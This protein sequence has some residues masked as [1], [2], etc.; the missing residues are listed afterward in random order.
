MPC[1]DNQVHGVHENMRA[2]VR[3]PG[4]VTHRQTCNRRNEL[5]LLKVNKCIVSTKHITCSACVLKYPPKI[6]HLRYC[7][8]SESVVSTQ[9]PMC[10]MCSFYINIS[11]RT[12]FKMS[13]QTAI[14]SRPLYVHHLLG[15]PAFAI[16][17]VD[18]HQVALFADYQLLPRHEIILAA[19][20]EY[21]RGCFQVRK[22]ASCCLLCPW[23]ASPVMSRGAFY[24]APSL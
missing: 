10:P 24:H 2:H 7:V 16:L 17:C 19:R 12:S 13:L 21:V 20:I 9:R 22:F 3:W 11:T 15:I 8:Q 1:G 4:S 14:S 18:L 6:P 5:Q 23:Y